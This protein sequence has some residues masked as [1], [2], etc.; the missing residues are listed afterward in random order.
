[1][2]G[3]WKFTH[4]LVP[5]HVNI[6]SLYVNEHSWD[7]QIN[8]LIHHY[9]PTI[10]FLIFI[11]PTDIESSCASRG[12]AALIEERILPVFLMYVLCF[13]I[14]LWTEAIYPLQTGVAYISNNMVDFLI[15]LSMSTYVSLYCC[16]VFLFS[17]LC[18]V[19]LVHY[20]I[21]LWYG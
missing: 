9:V 12:L 10:F 19:I 15:F 1:M 5:N 8:L 11:T 7:E 4:S 13:Y 17:G 14:C 6:F 2:H 21:M 3:L 16:A 20:K 18:R